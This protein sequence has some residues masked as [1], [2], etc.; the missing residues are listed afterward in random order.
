MQRAILR[1]RMYAHELTTARR[2]A[3]RGARPGAP[4]GA[5][6]RLDS[7]RSAPLSCDLFR[8]AGIAPAAVEGAGVPRADLDVS[9]RFPPRG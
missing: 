3:V 6:V 5:P 9:Q 2:E 8:S 7:R 4:R 1:S